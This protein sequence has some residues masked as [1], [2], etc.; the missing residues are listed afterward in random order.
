MGGSIYFSCDTYNL[1]D[2]EISNSTFSN[3]TA[4]EMGGAIYYDFRRPTLNSN[5]YLNN[6][7]E[8]GPNIGSYPIRIVDRSTLNYTVMLYEVGSGIQYPDLLEFELV[9]YDNQ[10]MVLDYTSQIKVTGYSAGT[11]LSG[12]DQAVTL[13]GIATFS[14]ITF[15]YIPGSSNI[16]YRLTS[17]SL[18]SSKLT[19]LGMNAYTQ[20]MVSFRYCM[21]GER[22]IGTTE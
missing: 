22:K 17:K 13:G 12:T 20:L 3:N 21:P 14:D 11:S 8:Y 5:T 15:K 9:D 2:V 10:T 19:A 1:C 4:S 18:D 16:E 6:T 7:S